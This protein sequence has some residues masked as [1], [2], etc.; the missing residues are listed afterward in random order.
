MGG[1]GTCRGAQSGIC[2]F[3]L[4]EGAGGAKGD[5]GLSKGS[6]WDERK[7]KVLRK[8]PEIQSRCSS[9]LKAGPGSFDMIPSLQG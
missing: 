8:C 4:G 3:H 1:R 7:A 2:S 9:F 5:L 6:E